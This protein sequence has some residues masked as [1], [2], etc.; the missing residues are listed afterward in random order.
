MNIKASRKSVNPKQR[1]RI[2]GIVAKRVES[3]ACRHRPGN[4]CLSP[5]RLYVEFPAASWTKVWTHLPILSYIIEHPDG[6]ILFETGISDNHSIEWPPEWSWMS[7]LTG[8]TPET[9]LEQNLKSIGL[10][11]DDFRYVVLGHLHSDHAGG[12]RLFQD[13]GAEIICHSEELNHVL[14]IT[15]PG[16]FYVP[17]DWAF[18]GTKK[19]TL[20]DSDQEIASGIQAV[21]FPGHTPGNM[22]LLLRLEHT[23]WIILGSDTIHVHENC[24]P[25]PVGNVLTMDPVQWVK[26]VEKLTDLAHEYEAFVFPGH[27]ETGVQFP[28]KRVNHSSRLSISNLATSTNKFSDRALGLASK[29]AANEE[30]GQP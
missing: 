5:S 20:I 26:S 10:S 29:M 15:E 23:G 8:I 11:P 25:P 27:D 30:G 6:L 4:T 3:W 13:A 1:R 19:P 14:K 17:E 24:G 21:A 18:L 7:D 9:C 16:D 12:M 22:G 28:R 2:D